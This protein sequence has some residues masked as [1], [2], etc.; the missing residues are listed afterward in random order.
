MRQSKGFLICDIMLKR[1]PRYGLVRLLSL[2]G[3][4]GYSDQEL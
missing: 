3:G 2:V 4:L 1:V